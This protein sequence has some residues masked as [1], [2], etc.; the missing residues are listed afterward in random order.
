MPGQEPVSGAAPRYKIADEAAFGSAPN[1]DWQELEVITHLAL[2]SCPHQDTAD[3]S[4]HIPCTWQC[5]ASGYK[6]QGKRQVVFTLL[7]EVDPLTDKAYT[8]LMLPPWP[9]WRACKAAGLPV[10]LLMLAVNEVSLA[11]SLQ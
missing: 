3:I 2:P 4:H 10:M 5:L 11:L 6:S 1:V 9:F 8:D 7:Q